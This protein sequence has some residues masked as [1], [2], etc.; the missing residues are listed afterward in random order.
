MLTSPI[1]KRITVIVGIESKIPAIFYLLYPRL[2][3]FLR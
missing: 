1:A 3:S 2:N